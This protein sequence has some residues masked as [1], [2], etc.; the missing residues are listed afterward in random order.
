MNWIDIAKVLVVNAAKCVAWVAGVWLV[1][2]VCIA[3]FTAIGARCGVRAS[4]IVWTERD[5]FER[6]LNWWARLGFR[7]GRRP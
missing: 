7:I 2:G 1:A 5:I 6:Y 3:S 4:D